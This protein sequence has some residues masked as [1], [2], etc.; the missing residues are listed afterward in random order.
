MEVITVSIPQM[1]EGLQEAQIVRHYARPGDKV[2]RDQ[3]LYQMETDKA[4]I[5]VEAPCDGRIEVWL[6]REGDML[7]IGSPVVTIAPEVAAHAEFVAAAADAVDGYRLKSGPA[8]RGAPIEPS[9]AAVPT[10][11]PPAGT[12]TDVVTAPGEWQRPAVSNGVEPAVPRNAR[13]LE[14]SARQRV[15]W[16]RMKQGAAMSVPALV[17]STLDY[18]LTHQVLLQAQK[19]YPALKLTAFELNAFLVSRAASRHPKFLLTIGA[20]EA[21][22]QHDHLNLGVAVA[23]KDDELST[24]VVKRANTLRIEEFIPELRKAIRGARRGSDQ[25][26]D[27]VQLLLSSLGSYGVHDAAP[28]LVPPAIATL[29][30]GSPLSIGPVEMMT[31]T[32]TFD[33]RAINGVGAGA[34]LKDIS[35]LLTTGLSYLSSDRT[36]GRT[37]ADATGDG[38]SKHRPGRI[39]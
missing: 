15:L 17:R 3:P 10:I 19:Q 11:R 6:C 5:D 4:L 31:I 38:A 33:H 30:F 12:R 7:A 34:F 21:L 32:L 20:T 8:W 29:F 22:Y 13:A 16:N 39:S 24:G 36:R 28:V 23:M 25:A 9:H 35:G 37:A 26:D 2:E 27:T 1:G 18:H 14:I